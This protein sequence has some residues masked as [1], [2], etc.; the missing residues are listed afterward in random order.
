MRQKLIC[1]MA[2]PRQLPWAVRPQNS[3][4]VC[5]SAEAPVLH[6]ALVCKRAAVRLPACAGRQLVLVSASRPAAR[7]ALRSEPAYRLAALS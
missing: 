2:A 3:L 6:S 1:T 4:S 7:P 5:R